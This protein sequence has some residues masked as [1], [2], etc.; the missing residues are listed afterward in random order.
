M[1]AIGSSTK[2][3]SRPC[4]TGS[5][6]SEES[7]ASGGG[8]ICMSRFPAVDRSQIEL[9][10]DGARSRVS[11]PRDGAFWEGYLFRNTAEVNSGYFALHG[12]WSK[13]VKVSESF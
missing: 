1:Q 10:L 11:P 3:K 5:G 4:V 13:G 6:L 9:T 8:K 7:R 12:P 2:S